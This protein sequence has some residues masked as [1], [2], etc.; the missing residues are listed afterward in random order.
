MDFRW[1]MNECNQSET[2]C[3]CWDKANESG[4]QTGNI[5]CHWEIWKLIKYMVAN[6]SETERSNFKKSCNLI[7]WKFSKTIFWIYSLKIVKIL[8]R[9]Y[10]L[11]IMTETL[12]KKMISKERWD[13]ILER[14]M[15]WWIWQQICP[16]FWACDKN[17]TDNWRR[18][19]QWKIF[20]DTTERF[21]L[22][23]AT[24]RENSMSHPQK[25]DKFKE[26]TF[27]TQWW[28]RVVLKYLIYQSDEIFVEHFTNE[29]CIIW[30]IG[31]S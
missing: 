9:Q 16:R 24:V 29:L 4:T 15:R 8:F 2:N 30:N 3:Q 13:I 23:I 6:F 12:R 11:R 25:F 10:N 1:N 17:L 7:F 28:F 21:H 14:H 31:R 5:N 22:T 26:K 20:Q 19:V 27:W 18:T